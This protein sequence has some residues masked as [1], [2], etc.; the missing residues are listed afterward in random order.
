M[1]D[2]LSFDF[3]QL[4]KL[5]A[6]LGEVGRLSGP[7]IN[8]AIKFT[9]VNI[10]KEAQATAGKGNRRWRALPAS[11]DFEVT[12]EAGV[13]GS[14]ITSEIGYNKDV[15]AG[16]LGN[17]REFG[18]SR[19]APHNDLLKALRKNEGDFEKGIYT[20]LG[21]GLRAAGL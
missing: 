19:V 1:A 7:Y 2:G 9:S 11:I 14:S 17:I 18:S 6:D 21:D 13:G 20:A 15:P 4:T 12:V 3:S 5:S 10:K 16:K 8:S